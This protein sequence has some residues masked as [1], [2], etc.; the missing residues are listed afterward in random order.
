MLTITIQ[1]TE[2]F[3]EKLEEFVYPES[4][5]LELEHSLVS[6]SKWESIFEKPFLG[7]DEKTTEELMH[8]IYLMI[9]T[10]GY[11]PEILDR[12]SEANLKEI[13]AYF[14]AKMTA[15]WFSDV[16]GGGPK[17]SETIT[18]E[19]IYYWM[20]AFSIPMECENWHLNR[21][22]TLIKISNLKNQKPKKMSA[23][24]VAARNRELNAK[25]LKELGTSG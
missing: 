14:D 25:R 13:Q 22:F 21:L 3:D 24:D 15:T 12:L 1:G 19:L 8:Y 23:K 18:S 17:S 20:S 9:I 11:T 2:F 5:V 7:K 16:P 10:P 4:F 6:L